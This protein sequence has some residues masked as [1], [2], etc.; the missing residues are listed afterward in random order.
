LRVSYRWLQDYVKCEL[1]AEELAEELTMV[2]L[3][4]EGVF[5]PVEGLDR[6][7]VGKILEIK[8]HPNA[9]NL[10]LCR[11]DTGSDIIQLVSGAPNLKTGVCAA[12]DGES[13]RVTEQSLC[14]INT[15]ADTARI[16]R[17]TIAGICIQLIVNSIADN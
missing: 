6:I 5:P 16:Y 14:N 15:G 4:V 9:E 10:M 7:I 11:V 3:E 17:T 12:N 8:P 13:M 2:G 1:P